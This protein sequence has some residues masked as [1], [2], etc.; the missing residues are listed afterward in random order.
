LY[1]I[2][3]KR[4]DKSNLIVNFVSM[5]KSIFMRKIVLLLLF[6]VNT[7]FGQ[8]QM[9]YQGFVHSIHNSEI[10][11]LQGLW[12]IN[13][14][15]VEESTKEYNLFPQISERLNY[16]NNI[17]FKADQTFVSSYSAPCGNDCFTTST[18]KYKIIDDNYICF[19]LD[20]ITRHGECSG[21]T[22]PNKDFGLYYFYKTENGLFNLIKSS[23]NVEQD[24]KNRIYR[25]LIIEKDKEIKQFGHINTYYND[26]FDWKQTNFTEENDIIAFCMNENQIKDYEILYSH[27]VDKYSDWTTVLLKANENFLF[28]VYAIGNKSVGLYD[29]SKIKEKDN[30]VNKIESDKKLKKKTFRETYIQKTSSS[31]KNTITI[32]QN[33]NEIQ[34]IVLKE[35]YSNGATATTTFYLQNEEPI[36]IVGEI[37]TIYNQNT[38]ISKTGF[39]I[40]DWKTH[41]F[42]VKEIQKN[43]GEVN[44]YRISEKYIRVKEDVNKQ[45]K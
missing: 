28:V 31:D 42:I 39:Y 12:G 18:G 3:S 5:V 8:Q 10:S 43:A 13:E 29:D 27:K 40:S 23:G 41:K 22:K 15:I 20:E 9:N 2:L 26:L 25:D 44:F 14:L 32:Y 30:L 16:G 11:V 35:Y 17:I 38:H 7:S 19:F 36:Y 1:A 24:K 4:T 21:V 45:F 33:K 6:V 37:N 34:K